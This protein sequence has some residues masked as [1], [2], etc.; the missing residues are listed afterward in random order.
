MI[1]SFKIRKFILPY[2]HHWISAEL[3]S[4]ILEMNIPLEAPHKLPQ[5]QVYLPKAKMKI[6]INSLG[7][8]NIHY[9]QHSAEYL[10]MAEA[11]PKS[12]AK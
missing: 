5:N 8:H 9:T 4:Q 10:T 6:S 2:F 7:Y 1:W 3:L 12:K 11:A